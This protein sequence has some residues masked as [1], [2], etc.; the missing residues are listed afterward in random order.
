MFVFK[1]L[2]GY[3]ALPFLPLILKQISIAVLFSKKAN[4]QVNLYERKYFM[5]CP[6]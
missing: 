2:I 4:I 5:A 3:M 6:K 1:L